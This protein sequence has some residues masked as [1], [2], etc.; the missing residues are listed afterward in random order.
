MATSFKTDIAPIFAPFRA[1]M[2]WRFDLTD[3][4][5]VMNNAALIASVIDLSPENPNPMPAPPMQPLSQSQVDLFNQWI[6]EKFPQ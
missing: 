4:D 3:Y 2:I 5:T 6:A 1:N